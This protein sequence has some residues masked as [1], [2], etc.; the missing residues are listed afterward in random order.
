MQWIHKF[1]LFLFDF[2]GL[3]VNTEH[4][5]YQAYVNTCRNRGV[6]LDWT[7]LKYCEA[8][9]FESLGVKDALLRQY[10]QLFENEVSWETVYAEKKQR[11]LELIQSGKVELMPGVEKLLLALAKEGIKSCV[12]TNSPKEQVDLVK[13]NLAVLG[14]I[15]HW[16]TREDYNEPKPNPDGY[17]TAIKRYRQP[18]DNVIGFED[19][20]KGLKALEQTPAK[21][22]LIC[23]KHHPQMEALFGFSDISHF[24]SFEE[25][26]NV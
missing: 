11:Y 16:L 14:T 23:P 10:P 6:N 1:Q 15:S 5:H 9:H 7:F 24:S 20:V 8:A 12:V 26:Q 13:A 3:L 25:I 4:L 17:L 2:D 18:K 19:T 21:A 22:V